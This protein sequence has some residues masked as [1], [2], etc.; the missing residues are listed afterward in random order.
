MKFVR[1][2][3][4]VPSPSDRI[5]VARSVVFEEFL[6]WPELQALTRFVYDHE[7]RFRASQVVSDTV[8]DGVDPSYRRSRVTLEVGRFGQLIADRI[9]NYFPQVLR[10]LGHVPFTIRRIEPQLTSSNDGDFFRLHNDN[11]QADAPSREITFVYF[12]HREPKPFTGGEL[13]LHDWRTEGEHTV[14]VAVRK[15]IVPEQNV[16]V[17]FPSACLHEVRPVVCPS[18]AFADSRFTINGWIH[19]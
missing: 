6:V 11:T 9:R 17:F 14:P 16:I 1:K 12:C 5:H 15:R 10:S 13:L 7:S 19:A 3:Q 2:R 18:R 8:A 4:I